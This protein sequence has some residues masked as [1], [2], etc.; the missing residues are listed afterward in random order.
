MKNITLTGT[1]PVDSGNDPNV[2]ITVTPAPAA[3]QTVQIG[4]T[5]V[6]NNGLTSQQFLFS[7]PVVAVPVANIAGPKIVTVGSTIALD[8]SGSTPTGQIAKFTWRLVPRT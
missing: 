5:V 6:D 8:G 4:L 7:V 2:T 3:G 1:T